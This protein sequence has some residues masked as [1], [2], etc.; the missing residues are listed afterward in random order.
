MKPQH[1][2]QNLYLLQLNVADMTFAFEDLWS[3]V[4]EEQTE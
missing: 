1:L 4:G 2:L 3:T